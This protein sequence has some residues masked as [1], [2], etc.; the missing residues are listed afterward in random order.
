MCDEWEKEVGVRRRREGDESGRR[1]LEGGER[2]EK[3]EA[4]GGD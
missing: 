4:V 2:R 3:D 1:R